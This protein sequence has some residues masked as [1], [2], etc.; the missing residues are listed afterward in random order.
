[1]T[2]N[3]P[4]RLFVTHLFAPDEAYFRVFEYLESQPNFFY[5]NLATPEKPPRSKEKEAIREDLRRQ[6]AD[7]EV[8]VLLSSLHARDPVLIEYQGLY[9]QSCDKPLVVME[10]FGTTDA[11]PAKLREMADEVVP[12][13][14]REIADAIRRQARH[15]DTTRWDTIEFKLD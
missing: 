6:M 10:P 15:E 11:V 8:V 12:W 4:I 14:G 7:A 3:N 9:A 2:E 13:N 1:M 5:T